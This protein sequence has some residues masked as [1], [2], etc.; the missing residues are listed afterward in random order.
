VST[1]DKLSG[2]LKK[3]AGGLLGDRSLRRQ[4]I[5]EERKAEAKED[6]ARTEEEIDERA[7]HVAELERRTTKPR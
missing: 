2:R 7:A 4:G 3:A 1:K 6:L 5:K